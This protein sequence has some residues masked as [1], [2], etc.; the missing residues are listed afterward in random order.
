MYHN[1]FIHSS[2]DGHLGCFHVLA[3]VNSAAVNIGI[4]V[5]FLKN[6]FVLGLSCSMWDLFFFFKLWRVIWFPGQGS[7]PGPLHWELGV[8]GTG[9]P[10][11]YTCLY[12]L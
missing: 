3:I 2:D 6:L 10:G 12:E 1:V 9:P 8:L 5:S 4:L 11:F 7:N